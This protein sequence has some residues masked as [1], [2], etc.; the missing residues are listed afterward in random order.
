MGGNRFF[1]RTRN[2]LDWG[3]PTAA[4]KSGSAEASGSEPK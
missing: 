3:K 1:G 4:E 2:A